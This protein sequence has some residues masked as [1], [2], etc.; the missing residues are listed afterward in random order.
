MNG[1]D[2][3][4]KPDFHI[5]RIDITQY[6]DPEL[7]KKTGKIWEVFLYNK[8]SYTHCC[9]TTPSYELGFV[10]HITEKHVDDETFDEVQQFDHQETK[11]LHCHVADAYSEG[12]NK[13]AHFTFDKDDYE[14]QEAYGDLFESCIDNERANPTWG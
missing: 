6:I 1:Y 8:N 7:V 14:D 11:Y 10:D 2:P 3:T 9:E 4:V 12:D 5:I 13:Q